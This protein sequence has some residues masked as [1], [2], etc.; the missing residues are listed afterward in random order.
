MSGFSLGSVTRPKFDAAISKCDREVSLGPI[1]PVS[2]VRQNH[3]D[4]IGRF[5]EYFPNTLV[6]RQYMTVLYLARVRIHA[7]ARAAYRGNPYTKS[8]LSRYLV[9]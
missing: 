2:G 4:V 8:Y 6:I 1:A 7:W 3:A 5:N 9:H